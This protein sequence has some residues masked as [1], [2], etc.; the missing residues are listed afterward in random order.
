MVSSE[1]LSGFTGDPVADP[2]LYRSLVGALQYAVI[3]RP[4]MAYAI[5]K[6]SQFMHNLLEPHFKVVKKILRYFKGTLD[7]ELHLKSCSKLVLKG[8]YDVDWA[9]DPDDRRSTLGFCIYLGY[10]MIS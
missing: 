9:S 3:T 4:E 6:V 10:N 1:K 7:Y 5:N 8:F 2:H